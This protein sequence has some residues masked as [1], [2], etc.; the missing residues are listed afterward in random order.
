MKLGIRSLIGRQGLPTLRTL[1][2]D[3][4][5]V[6]Q[7]TAM[8][9]ML[10]RRLHVPKRH[11]RLHLKIPGRFPEGHETNRA[12]IVLP[13]L[14]QINRLLIAIIKDRFKHPFRYNYLRPILP[15]QIKQSKLYNKKSQAKNTQC[16]IRLHTEYIIRKTSK[17]KLS[18][19]ICTMIRKRDKMNLI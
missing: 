15:L 17:I 6:H 13:S 14:L 7:T 4:H 9:A 8:V 10:A 18:R 3:L 2:L 16:I 1:H 12:V 19:R 11:F 5:P